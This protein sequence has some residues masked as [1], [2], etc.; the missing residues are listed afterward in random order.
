M[1]FSTC[2]MFLF[3]RFFVERGVRGLNGPQGMLVGKAD[4]RGESGG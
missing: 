1:S 2:P 4:E 3:G